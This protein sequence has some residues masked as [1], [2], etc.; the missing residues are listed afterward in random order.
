MEQNTVNIFLYGKK[1]G[2]PRPL[3]DQQDAG[4]PY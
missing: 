2:V 3:T 1:S 4:T